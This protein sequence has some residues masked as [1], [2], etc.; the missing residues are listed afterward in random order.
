MAHVDTIFPI[1]KKARDKWHFI[2]R[3]IGVEMEDLREI[4]QNNNRDKTQCLLQMLQNRIEEGGLTR[5]ML[6]ASL[7]GD[8]VRRDDVAQLIEKNIG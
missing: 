2:G 5:S 7:R 6:C 8:N 3:G 4:E 1:M